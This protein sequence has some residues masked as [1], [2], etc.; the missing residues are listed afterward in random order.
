MLLANNSLQIDAILPYK[1]N[2]FVGNMIINQETKDFISRHSDEDVRKVAL[3][4]KPAESVDLPFALQQ[5]AGRQTAKTKLPSWY[6]A[7]DV[8]FPPHI[9]MEQCSSEQ[10]AE[11]KVAVLQS[12]MGLPF[13]IQYEAKKC[14]F[15]DFTGGFGVDFSYMA[16][17]FSSATYI[18]RQEHLCDIA[19]HNLPLLGLKDAEVVCTDSVEAMQKVSD[20]AHGKPIVVFMDPARRDTNGQRTYAIA[21][22]T[23]DVTSCIDDLLRHTQVVMIKLSP[24]L[25]WHSAV[26]EL[27]DAAQSHDA[28]R[29]IHIVSVGNECK[30]LLLLLSDKYSSPLSLHCVNDAERFVIHGV[31]AEDNAIV[32]AT[33]E[34]SSHY[35]EAEGERKQGNQTIF[36]A[37][38]LYVPNASVMKAGCFSV[39][40]NAF[41]IRQISLN[42]HLF[43]AD[44]MVERFPGRAFRVRTVTTMNKK[45][46]RKALDGVTKANIATRN[47][48]ISP[49]N[50]RKKLK[51]KDGGE[52]YIFAT[53]TADNDHIL[54][55]CDKNNMQKL[56]K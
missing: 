50:L 9:S 54:I 33:A 8:I 29:E 3:S 43:F 15:I 47:F 10:T 2:N 37:Q 55:V 32:S 31:S 24:M 5:I 51:L 1:S 44:T 26:R 42:S 20:Y 12:V 18:E 4:G 49:E 28:V 16:K 30:E 41:P 17:P 48:P 23:P 52:T 13:T 34:A 35:S 39:L 11:Y 36:E 27:N 46:L 56:Y 21:D 53:T 40:E 45:E 25:D 7:E 38:Y 22:C 14:H 6:A 19:Q